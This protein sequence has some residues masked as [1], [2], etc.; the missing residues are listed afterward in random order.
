M[1]HEYNETKARLSQI[2]PKRSLAI[3]AFICSTSYMILFQ[4]SS[5]L[6]AMIPF[7][8][9]VTKGVDLTVLNGLILSALWTI[10][11]M[12][13]ALPFYFIFG[14][15][16]ILFIYIPIIGVVFYKK[17]HEKASDLFL[18]LEWLFW[19]TPLLCWIY[20]VSI[21]GGRALQPFY[22]E[23]NE[24]LAVGSIPL[25]SDVSF[26]ASKQINIVINMCKE[27]CGPKSAYEQFK[28]SQIHIPTP[29]IC[30]PEFNDVMKG[31]KSTIQILKKS[32]NSKVFVHCK[33]GRARATTFALILLIVTSGAT[34]ESSDEVWK[35]A[36]NLIHLLKSKRHVIEVE[37]LNFRV[38]QKFIKEIV[39]CKGDINKLFDKTTLS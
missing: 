16:I 18:F 8:L 30:E 34:L 33:A 28:I 26:L 13:I 10:Y 14:R 9:M 23:I 6:V 31:L 7:I 27:Y 37:V 32:K 25:E 2:I 19:D 1:T 3:T 38:V 21:T 36:R 11:T 4:N 5:S 22:S 35:L 39:E 15:F 20:L 17:P 24:K 29:D 12:T